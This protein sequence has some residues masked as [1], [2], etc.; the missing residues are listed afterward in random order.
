MSASLRWAAIGISARAACRSRASASSAAR[1]SF[2]T[3]ATSEA[4]SRRNASRSRRRP[5][6]RSRRETLKS[7]CRSSSGA[8]ARP[9]KRL[10]SATIHPWRPLPGRYR[11]SCSHTSRQ[12]SAPAGGTSTNRP[13][14]RLLA[15][16]SGGC[17]SSGG[18]GRSL[19]QL[20]RAD[21]NHLDL[22]VRRDVAVQA[23]VDLVHADVLDGVIELDAALVHLDA[24]R[25][26]RVGDLVGGDGAEEVA[27]IADPLLDRDLRALH[28]VGRLLGD[29]ALLIGQS[30]PL[31][32][33]LLD[34]LHVAG[35]RL[36]GEILRDEEITGVAVLDGHDV[37]AR[38]EAADLVSQ[39]DLHGRR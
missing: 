14:T 16:F 12:A 5:A 2:C 36:A 6:R 10:K 39:N 34:G 24:L 20:L 37:A 28:G 9:M 11:R 26:E 7:R 30:G 29:G 27:V 23:H 13:P 25:G 32:L 15:G 18:R 17:G 22:D 8:A 38:T 31:L 4:K 1:T 21:G 35:R 3:A 33:L 19:F